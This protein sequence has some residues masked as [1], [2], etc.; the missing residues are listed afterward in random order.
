LIN[1]WSIGSEGIWINTNGC[2]RVSS[3]IPRRMLTP[4]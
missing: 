2:W 3:A 4:V 1:P